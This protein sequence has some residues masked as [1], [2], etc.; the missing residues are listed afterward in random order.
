MSERYSDWQMSVHE[1]GHGVMC[2]H[3]GFEIVTIAVR[4]IAVTVS[5]R[6]KSLTK[7]QEQMRTTAGIA[8]E[9]VVFGDQLFEKQRDGS[10]M[11][12][13][14]GADDLDALGISGVELFA[15]PA[16]RQTLQIMK[17]RKSRITK[18]ATALMKHGQIDAK[19]NPLSAED[20]LKKTEREGAMAKVGE[21]F[22][23]VSKAWGER[24]RS[25]ETAQAAA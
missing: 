6:P 15:L 7:Y 11:I 12:H 2:E 10:L 25:T 22:C 20:F 1:T 5:V 19:L 8:A 14:A 17:R 4:P 16:F 9:I 21:Q 24:V 3:L 13:S 23:P 18:I